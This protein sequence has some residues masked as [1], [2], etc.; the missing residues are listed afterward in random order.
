MQE[1]RGTNHGRLRRLA[2]G[3]EL[4]FIS[5]GIALE[6]CVSDWVDIVAVNLMARQRD[7]DSIGPGS[8]AE[9]YDMGPDRDVLSRFQC[10][11]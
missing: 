11:P 3:V 8:R 7:C 9:I 10:A 1:T 5:I 6:Q 2:I 4:H